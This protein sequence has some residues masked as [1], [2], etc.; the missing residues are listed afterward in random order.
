[1]LLFKKVKDKLKGNRRKWVLVTG[2]TRVIFDGKEYWV[3][4]V[5]ELND[6]ILKYIDFDGSI[7]IVR[8]GRKHDW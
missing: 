3:R 4:R 7:K 2:G 1:M 5:L 6:N 8:R